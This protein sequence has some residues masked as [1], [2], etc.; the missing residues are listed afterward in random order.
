AG[1]ARRFLRGR[2]LSPGLRGAESEPT[3]HRLC[4]L[5]EGRQAAR[6][7]CREVKEGPMIIPILFLLLPL[8]SQQQQ[9]EQQL[10]RQQQQLEQIQRELSQQ[11][12]QL[13]RMLGVMERQAQAERREEQKP[14]CTVE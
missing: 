3:L 1:T 11:Q 9:L 13:E 12:Q 8:Q 4:R 6:E 10:N 2:G 14:T 7:F 5:A